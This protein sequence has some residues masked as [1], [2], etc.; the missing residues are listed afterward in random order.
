MCYKRHMTP[1]ASLG[2]AAFLLLSADCGMAQ[3]FATEDPFP[4]PIVVPS[5][6]LAAIKT[7]ADSADIL[8][9]CAQN[10]GIRVADVPASWFLGSQFELS[11][12]RTSGL[13][14][15]AEHGCLLGAHI[16]QFWVL[17]KSQAGYQSV[18]TGR[19]DALSVLRHRT[20]GY[21]DVQLIFVM[22]A[23]AEIQYVTFQYSDG[24]YRLSGRRTEH[25]N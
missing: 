24:A 9:D 6:A 20:N 25:P 8:R 23:G 19:A 14:V 1:F 4:N 15:R 10:E 3:L 12:G 7:A 18:F 17:A 2:L 5:E 16:T 11:K 22:K 21:R 13:I